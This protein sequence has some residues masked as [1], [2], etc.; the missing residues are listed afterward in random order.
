MENLKI[1]VKYKSVGLYVYCNKCKSYSNKSDGYLRKSES[2]AHPPERQVFKL[3]VHIPNTRN[4]CRTKV[5]KTRDAKEA[6]EKR[7]EFIKLL[8]QNGYNLSS[9]TSVKQSEQDRYLLTYQMSR[10]I[11]FIT[12]GGFYEFESPKELEK[13][14]IKDYQRH[15]RYFLESLSKNVNIRSVKVNEIDKPHLELFHNYIKKKTDS[16]K[17]YGNIMTSLKRFFNHLIR[18]EKFPISNPFTLVTIH[19]VEYDPLTF[20]Q[21]EFNRVLSVTTIE[22]GFDNNEKRNRFR[23]WLPT[24]FKLGLFSCLRLDELVHLKFKDIVTIEGVTVL[25]AANQ[26]ANKLIGEHGG[27]KKR[28]KRIAVIQELHDVLINECEFEKNSAKDEYIIAPD[29]SRSTARDIIGKGFTQ[30]KR[31][32]GIDE[33]KCFKDL[34][35][36]F[37]NKIHT[38]YGDIVLTTTVSDHSS[39]DVVRKHYL[40]QIE[41]A[42][43]TKGLKIFRN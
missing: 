29:V 32:A 3:M 40:S 9:I 8:E 31:I 27:K 6:E 17:T 13:E 43:K 11:D 38:Q 30:F 15:F 42:K 20:T 33:D 23:E 18:Y 14:T 34:R 41:A 19:S 2:C 37:M 7:F 28:I 35:G 5:L 36:T 16:D 24:A 39:K 26:K 22:N 1:P 21:E 12:N 4:L 10:F 25:E